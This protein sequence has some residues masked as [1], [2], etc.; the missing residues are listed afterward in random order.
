MA[1]V[2]A[3]ETAIEAQRKAR[4]DKIKVFDPVPLAEGSGAGVPAFPSGGTKVMSSSALR[5]GTIVFGCDS[6]VWVV[7]RRTNGSGVCVVPMEKVVQVE[8]LEEFSTL[9]VLAD[10]TLYTFPLDVVEPSVDH[11]PSKNVKRGR[12]V[13][14]HI[15][16]F[17]Y[18][19][20]NDRRIV[21]AVKTAMYQCTV[22][23][24]VPAGLEGGKPRLNN[25]GENTLKLWK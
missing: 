7:G 22:R 1:D 11:L 23:A 16:F 12:K 6:G 15:N 8:T 10:K 2:A 13:A 17:R 25:E 24:L 19:T 4:V 14:S 20:S 9:V 21:C 3:W 5:D 18:G